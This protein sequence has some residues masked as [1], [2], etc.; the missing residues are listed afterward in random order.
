MFYSLLQA[1][2]LETIGIENINRLLENFM[3]IND[4]ELGMKNSYYLHNLFQTPIYY[5][6]LL[7]MKKKKI[8]NYYYF[9]MNNLLILANR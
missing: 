7:N 8:N 9:I 4:E 6:F 3:G 1:D 2:D 5:V